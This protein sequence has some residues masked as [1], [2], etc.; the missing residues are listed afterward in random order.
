MEIDDRAIETS[1]ASLPLGDNIIF[2]DSSFFRY[3]GPHA[4]LPTPGMV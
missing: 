2:P 1:P 4:E 3:N